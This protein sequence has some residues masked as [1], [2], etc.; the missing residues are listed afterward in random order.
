MTTMSN[1]I[2]IVDNQASP[3]SSAT[4][5]GADNGQSLNEKNCQANVL[6]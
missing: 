1:M 2:S 5:Q 4:S 6:Q 3:D